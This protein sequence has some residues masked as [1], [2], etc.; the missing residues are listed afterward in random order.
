MVISTEISRAVRDDTIL[1]SPLVLSSDENHLT[2]H[3]PLVYVAHLD[4]RTTCSS[5]PSDLINRF[6]FP[7]ASGKT[8]SRRTLDFKT[9]SKAQSML[10][11]TPIMVGPSELTETT[12]RHFKK[13]KTTQEPGPEASKRQKTTTLNGNDF[14]LPTPS[15]VTAFQE[16]KHCSL[17]S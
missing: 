10:Q 7:V 13:R 14:I 4:L 16:V 3:E 6:H 15:E 9:T 1:C 8:Q 5:K 2:N 17:R 11:A 12:S